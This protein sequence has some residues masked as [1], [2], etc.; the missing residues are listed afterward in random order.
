MSINCV[1]QCSICFVN[2]N[3]NNGYIR[4]IR[5]VHVNDRQFGT[6]CALCDSKFVFTNLKSFI[7]HFR[8]HMLH[9]LF[10][11]VPTPDL[12]VNHDIINSDVNDDFEE[13]LTIPEYEHY[14]QLEEIK[15]FYLKMLLRVREGH[16]LP[17]AV[18][19]T[20]SL[21]VCS[22]LERFSIFL[23]SKLN[24]NLDNPILRHVNGDIEK[25][26]F[27][28]SKNEEL[29]ISDC[30]LYFRFIKPKEIQLPTGNTAYYIPICDILMCLFQKKDFYECIKREKKYI[31]QFDG[32][33]I[34]YHYRNGEIGRQH[35][36]LKIKENTILLQL[37][38][39]DISVVNPL[40]GKNA[41]HKL[42]TFYLS[43]DDLPAC[44][45]SSLNF[46][47]LLLLFYRKDFEN[48]NN[49]QILFNLL[50]KDIECLENDGLILPG[51]ITPTYFTISTLCAD[52]LAAHELGGFTCSFNSGR[53]CRYCLIHHKDMKYVYRE[54]D[55]LIRTA[56]SH[57]FHVKHIDNV[58]NDKSLYGVNEKSIL[59]TLLSF[60]PITSLPPDIM[61]DILEGIMPK[62]ISS[63][64]HTIVSTRLCT[65]AQI[66]YRI[67]NFI[68]GINDRRNRPPTFKEKD[69]HD[70]RVPGKA[71]EKYCLFLN[72]GLR[73]MRT[74]K[75]A[76]GTENEGFK[77]ERTVSSSLPSPSSSPSPSLT[78]APSSALH[79]LSQSPQSLRAQVSPCASFGIPLN[80]PFILMDIVNRIPYWFLYELL[81]Q[82][83][84]I[85]YSDYPRK[86]WL[87]TLEDLIQEFL[88]L[89]QT[90]FP[91]QFIPKCHFLLHAARNTAKYGPLKRQMNLR[92]ESK[93]HLLKKIANRCNNYINL[94]CTISKR[95]QLRQCYELMEE[96]IFKCS[97]ISGK[98]HSR[99][100]ISF[101]KEIQNALRDD[102][103]FDYDELTEYVKWVVLNNIKYKIGDVFVFYLLGGEEIPL[104]GEIKYIINNKKAWRFIVHCYETI[105][106]RENLHCYEISPSNAYVVIDQQHSLT[107]SSSDLN[108]SS[109]SFDQIPTITTSPLSREVLPDRIINQ[110]SSD[111]VANSLPQLRKKFPLN[112]VLPSFSRA[113]V[114]A[115]EDPSLANFGP[116]CTMKQQ[117]VKTIRGDV[118]NTYGIG[119]YPT[120]YEF[121]R[122][123]VSVKN[124]IP[125]LTKIF[126]EDMSVLTSAL[127]QQ[128]SRDRK[129][130]NCLSEVLEKKRQSYG[131]QS[132][133]RKLKFIK[134][135]LASRREYIV[136][137]N[138]Q[139][140]E[141]LM[142]L[143]QHAESMRV[144]INTTNYDYSQVKSKMD[145]TYS[146]RK[147][148][149]QEMKPVKDIVELYPALAITNLLIREINLRCDP[150]GGDIVKTLTSVCTKLI[151]YVDHPRKED[152][153]EEQPFFILEH[154]IMKRFKHSKKLL[155][156]HEVIDAHP[157]IQVQSIDKVKDYAIIIEY[158]RLI[159]TNSQVEAMAILIGSY[160]IF[161]IE[162]PSKIRATLEVLNGLSFTKRSFC[163]S[164]AAK[165]FLNG[166]K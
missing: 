112:Y 9:S 44:Y 39:D 73:M 3:G 101:R 128:F 63:L 116:R 71:M 136:E 21:S 106:F 58:P 7:S 75:V 76:H 98:F 70:K 144:M 86:S 107:I 115:A 166:H 68:Y 164:L 43:I 162:Y 84:D 129:A 59:S 23:L 82:I 31:C 79:S 67:N 94:P 13:Q 102:Y 16:I 52:N 97:G 155:L 26:L 140:Q 93:H 137:E 61:H 150:F 119:F 91:E 163:V 147:Q 1:Q 69:I 6:P 11:E 47:H 36:I 33:D 108:T 37:Y 99:R 113:F 149:V 133:G 141:L 122:M 2:V 12:C 151:K 38:C 121:D 154:L 45:N 159:S 20:I 120:A 42:T 48:E 130:S 118:V 146:H 105:S 72:L 41:A 40:M 19:K 18:M 53:C 134:L 55:V 80:L 60:N 114:E 139:P 103:L 34:I 32:Q 50:N 8:K 145:A 74:T 24:I 161:Y 125:T 110:T 157:M 111:S 77:A 165:R 49:R 22:L 92:Y 117:L 88:Q 153:P 54:A 56:A 35:C 158:N 109:S 160:E 156:N 64:L 131:H 152:V 96:N 124:K 65:S 89:F 14:D 78:S 57:D 132:S 28:I 127:K 46:I 148:L 62:I 100:K 142:Q 27:E 85:L 135:E 143:Y 4:H 17:G 123:V 126:G 25:I 138:Q 10:D 95:V 66:C 90:I 87:S 81:R 30:E 5:Q 51:D 104:F 83:W 29:F 15:K